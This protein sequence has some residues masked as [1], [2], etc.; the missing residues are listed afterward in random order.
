EGGVAKRAIKEKTVSIDLKPGAVLFENFNPALMSQAVRAYDRAKGGKQ[1]VP[2]FILP[3]A[4][5]SASLERTDD[6]ER[7]VGGKDVKLTRYVYALPG[8]DVT[9]WADAANSKVYLAD[10]PAQHDFYVREGYEA[11]RKAPDTD[12]RLPKPRHKVR[13]ERNLGVPMRDGLKLATDIYRP[14]AEGKH[15]VILI[16]TPYKKDVAEL[17]G[18][19]FARR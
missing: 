6:V 10:V 15:P 14:E 5:V 16:R 13:V 1:T 18:Q 9:V 12:P 19:Y 7:S 3:G 17:D 11:L 4:T 8:V 2:L